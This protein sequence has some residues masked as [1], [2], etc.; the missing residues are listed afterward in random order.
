MTHF[1]IATLIL[2]A[3]FLL[4]L[5]LPLWFEKRRNTQV[6]GVSNPEVVKQR[7]SELEQEKQ[8]SL[9]TESDY[10]EAVLETKFS[11]ADELTEDEVSQKGT[12]KV[13]LGFVAVLAVVFSLWV[14][15]DIN[16][17][18]EVKDWQRAQLALPELGQ[19]IVVQADQQVSAEEL[20][21]FALALRTKLHHQKD[22]AVGWLLLGRVLSSLRDFEGAI[23]AFEKSLDI[24]PERTGTLFSLAQA[25]LVTADEDN[26]AR[27]QRILERLK[28]MTPSDDNVL[29]LLAVAY[30]RND[31]I[32]QAVDTWQ[33]LKAR[34]PTGDPM[35]STINQQLAALQAD[36]VDAIEQTDPE[37]SATALDIVVSIQPELATHSAASGFLFVFVQDS[38]S[39]NKMPVAVKKVSAKQLLE[40]QSVQITLSD[41]DAMLTG[42]NLSGIE[43]GRLI[44]RVSKDENV[45]PQPGELQ[46]EIVITIQQG[47]RTAHT[48][49]IDKEL[50]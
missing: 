45:A 13:L 27:A 3:I 23:T 33:T 31:N 32:E 49:Q 39:D 25:L 42:F 44:A 46:G 50:Q 18:S 2:V 7:L 10:D 34:I 22:D 1:L 41:Q 35:L 20:S 19:K 40:Q 26:M 48:I 29:G 36:D 14:Y 15:Y 21:E 16:N 38:N 8:E 5:L 43:N 24:E 47:K 37:Q 11:L 12:S 9:L 28:D 6:K 30:T 17:L 4:F